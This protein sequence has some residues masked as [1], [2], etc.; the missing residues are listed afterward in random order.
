[1]SKLGL[2]FNQLR[3]VNVERC[4]EAF[5]GI[6]RWTPTDWACAMA[7]E[8]GEVCN[9]IKKIRRRETNPDWSTADGEINLE[10]QVA[11]ELADL[12]IY[13]DL[14]AARLGIDL[15]NAIVHKFNE[16][17]HKQW[18]G[19]GY[20]PWLLWVKTESSMQD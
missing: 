9:V 16:V 18:K 12:V 15:G 17:S 1:M 20:P 5:H 13:A 10:S 6:D 14:L 19:A 4:E 11:D 3:K 8:C 2:T 7:G